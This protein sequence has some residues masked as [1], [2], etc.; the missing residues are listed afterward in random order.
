MAE[1]EVTEIR[2]G[3]KDV[4]EE[5]LK[6]ID[7]TAAALGKPFPDE[8]LVLRVTRE[9]EYLGGIVCEVLQGWLYIKYLGIESAARGTGIGGELMRRA[10]RWAAEKGLVGTY[11]DTFDFQAPDFYTKLGY[12]EL[13]R[14]PTTKGHAAR[15]F[16]SKPFVEE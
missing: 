1:I 7:D 10:E 12:R 6:T 16:Y 15:I 4:E 9:G 14:L 13:G 11:V 2:D 3:W 5:I 8:G